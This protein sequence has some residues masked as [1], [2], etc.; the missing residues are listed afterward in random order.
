MYHSLHTNMFIARTTKK[1]FG[2]QIVAVFSNVIIF[3]FYETFKDG[4]G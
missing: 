1:T 4:R 2:F 3:H